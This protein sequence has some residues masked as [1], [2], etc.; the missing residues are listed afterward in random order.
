MG[1]YMIPLFF[2]TIISCSDAVSIVNRLV[3][4]VG[5]T[6][7]QKVEIVSELRKIVPT[8]PITIKKDEPPKK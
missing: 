8:C 6:P 4:V 2:S 3:S 7:K 5:L 1:G